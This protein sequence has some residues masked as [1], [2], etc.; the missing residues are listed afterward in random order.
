M[1]PSSSNTGR[2]DPDHN[3]NHNAGNGDTIISIPFED[4]RSIR[5]INTHTPSQITTPDTIQLPGFTY[6]HD[7]SN[8]GSLQDIYS[9]S[10]IVH[11]P[12]REDEES[13]IGIMQAL[14]LTDTR[15]LIDQEGPYTNANSTSTETA[16][17]VEAGVDQNPSTTPEEEIPS[18]STHVHVHVHVQTLNSLCPIQTTLIHLQR[19]ISNI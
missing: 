16:E 14:T 5:Y 8:E 11:D 3:A 2:E 4:E 10:L 13:N 17:N 7:D 19:E 1:S 15:L 9:S 12:S 18:T 6:R